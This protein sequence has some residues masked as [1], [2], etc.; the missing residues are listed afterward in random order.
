MY[1]QV[2][3]RARMRVQDHESHRAPLGEPALGRHALS[4]KNPVRTAL[5]WSVAFVAGWLAASYF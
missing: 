1:D 4:W 2:V 3:T 5:S